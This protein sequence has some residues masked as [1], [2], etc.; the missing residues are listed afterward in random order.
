M[1]FGLP[2]AKIGRKMANDR[3]LHIPSTAHAT[4]QQP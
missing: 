4:S 3:L 1:D 2:N